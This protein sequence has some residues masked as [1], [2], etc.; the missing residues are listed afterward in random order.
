MSEDSTDRGEELWEGFHTASAGSGHQ[1][2]YPAKPSQPSRAHGQAQT[3][4]RD[5]D[6]CE[7]SRARC[8]RSLNSAI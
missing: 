6:H 5:P 7:C 8:T 4:S 3:Q 1:R 2:R